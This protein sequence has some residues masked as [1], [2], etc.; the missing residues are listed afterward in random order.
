MIVPKDQQ[1]CVVKLKGNDCEEYAVWTESYSIYGAGGHFQFADG[2]QSGL[3]IDVDK[4]WGT[5]WIAEEH[6]GITKAGQ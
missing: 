2:R 4:W 5:C 3:P 6:S 1:I